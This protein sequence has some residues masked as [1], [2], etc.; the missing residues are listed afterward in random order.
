MEWSIAPTD[1][2]LG[3]HEIVRTDS[4]D[5]MSEALFKVYK[6]RLVSANSDGDGFFGL[7]NRVQFKH[8]GLVFCA[9]D[10]DVTIDFS[11]GEIVRQQIC[12]SGGGKTFAEGKSVPLSEEAACVIQSGTKFRTQFGAG[13]RHLLLCVDPKA[14]RRKL[15]AFVGTNLPS[16]IAFRPA[17]TFLTPQAKMLRR[18]ALFSP[19][20]SNSR[21]RVL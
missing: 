16:P 14:L 11:E 3:K 15:E 2:L 13:Y 9:F 1:C 5:R 6:G 21:K 10:F 8:I 20:K 12:L 4:V 7:T 17:Q 19:A 18:S